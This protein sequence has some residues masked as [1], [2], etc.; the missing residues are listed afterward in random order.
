MNF[1][2]KEF[3]NR[4]I[5][6]QLDL[7]EMPQNALWAPMEGEGPVTVKINDI[8]G[9]PVNAV[10]PDTKEPLQPGEV[11]AN[12]VRQ[13]PTGFRMINFTNVEDGATITRYVILDDENNPLYGELTLPRAKKYGT[14]WGGTDFEKLAKQRIVRLG[15]KQK[16]AGHNPDDPEQVE[17][18][19]INQQKFW[20]DSWAKRKLVNPAFNQFFLQPS[21]IKHLDKCGIPEV[22]GGAKFTEP[23]TNILRTYS[24]NGPRI[25]FNY[26]SVRDDN[27]VQDALDKIISYRTSLETGEKMKGSRPEPT[28]MVRQYGGNVYPGGKWD[29]TQRALGKSDFKLTPVYKLYM[30]N[31]QRGEKAFNVITDVDVL[32]DVVGDSYL[33][34]MS[35]S[36]TKSFR[37]ADTEEGREQSPKR[38]NLFEP[39]RV[40]MRVPLPDGD[41]T[42]TAREH[43]G[44]F[45]QLFQ[46]TLTELGNRILDIDPDSVLEQLM[47]EPEEVLSQPTQPNN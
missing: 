5:Q 12:I 23:S 42:P 43:Y 41:K 15:I 25:Q 34:T 45:K 46:D 28:K 32:G 36:A 27:D 24:Y 2:T 19:K 26:H 18:E 3:I 39:I 9:V 13:S 14:D 31:V 35:F 44:F 16:K 21:I 11:K 17:K 29:P 8:K 1:I 47:F 40:Q 37:P 10:D 33:M 6:E 4:L 22:R 7:T 30:K 38:G 20:N